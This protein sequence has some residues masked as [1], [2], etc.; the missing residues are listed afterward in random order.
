MASIDR[1]MR[2]NKSENLKS[3][4]WAKRFENLG[5]E[6]RRVSFHFIFSAQ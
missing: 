5:G 2:K 6:G 3:K 1:G 4:T